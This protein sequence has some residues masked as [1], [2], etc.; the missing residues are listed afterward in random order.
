[1]IKGAYLLLI[2]LISGFLAEN[3][4]AQAGNDSEPMTYDES[5]FIIANYSGV[6]ALTPEKRTLPE[7]LNL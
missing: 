1:M 3:L 2:I 4:C 5:I 7:L 6:D